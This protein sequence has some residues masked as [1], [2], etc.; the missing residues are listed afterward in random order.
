[1]VKVYCKSCEHYSPEESSDEFGPHPARCLFSKRNEFNDKEEYHGKLDDNIK[2][3][4][5]NHHE[6]FSLVRWICSKLQLKQN[7]KN[8]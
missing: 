2:G 1:M 7:T 5:P 4:C 3:G 6:K 8:V